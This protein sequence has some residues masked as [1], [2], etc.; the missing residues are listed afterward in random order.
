[1]SKITTSPN[2]GDIVAYDADKK[3]RFIRYDGSFDGIPTGLTAM[4]V[5]SSRQGNEV[6]IP[7]PLLSIQ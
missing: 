6:L 4:G 1:M 5:V 2:K 7:H 3:V